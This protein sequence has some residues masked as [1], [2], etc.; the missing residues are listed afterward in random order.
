MKLAGE[1]AVE[2]VPMLSRVAAVAAPIDILL[3]SQMIAKPSRRVYDRFFARA[4]IKLAK[5]RQRF[6]KDVPLPRFPVDPTI[7]QFDD[8]FTAPRC[9]FDNALDYYRKA[10]ALPVVPH[11]PI[12]TLMIT[13]RDDPF[14]AV[15]PYENLNVPPHVRVEIHD[16]GGHLGFLGFDGFGGVRWAERRVAEWILQPSV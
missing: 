4:M 16:R 8:L 3:C 1:A 10:S 13:S 15:E 14:V 7:R 11:I 5:E 2:P 12:S 6:H 9:G